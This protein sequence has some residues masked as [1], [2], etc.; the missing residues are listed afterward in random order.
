MELNGWT[1]PAD[2]APLR[3]QRP[4]R[5]GPPHLRPHHGRPPMTRPAMVPGS[6]QNLAGVAAVRHGSNRT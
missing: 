1:S 5:P 3:G 2:A 6:D 4:Q